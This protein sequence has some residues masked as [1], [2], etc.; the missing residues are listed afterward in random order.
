METVESKAVCVQGMRI[1]NLIVRVAHCVI[2]NALKVQNCSVSRFRVGCPNYIP[3]CQA[4]FV[5][6]NGWAWD[7]TVHGGRLNPFVNFR[8]RI[9][10]AHCKRGIEWTS[11]LVEETRRFHS[12]PRLAGSMSKSG[13]LAR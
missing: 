2:K 9:H 10:L 7:T 5:A 4:A 3:T 8:S 1:Q 6:V 13:C 12:E 11:R